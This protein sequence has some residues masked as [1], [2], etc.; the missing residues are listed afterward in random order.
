MGRRPLRGARGVNVTLPYERRRAVINMGEA[1]REMLPYLHRGKGLTVRVPRETLRGVVRCLR[2][3]PT[4]L[5]VEIAAESDPQSW[6]NPATE[7]TG[8]DNS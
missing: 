8:H 6:G 3:Y 5:D 1:A 4:K 7:G 2:H